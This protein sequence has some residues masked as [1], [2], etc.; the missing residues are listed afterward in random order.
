MLSDSDELKRH[1]RFN[2]LANEEMAF[3]RPTKH[4][5][6]FFISSPA[7]ESNPSPKFQPREFQE[8]KS[9]HEAQIQNLSTVDRSDHLTVRSVGDEQSWVSNG[10]LI[11][12]KQQWLVSH[13][14]LLDCLLGTQVSMC[15]WILAESADVSLNSTC[16]YLI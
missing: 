1:R 14:R 6:L 15:T 16:H 4:N 3:Y 11:K 9:S 8:Y 12:L 13:L 2:T 10:P 5:S 7:S